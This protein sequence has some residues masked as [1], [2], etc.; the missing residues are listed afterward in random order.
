MPT[1]N[2]VIIAGDSIVEYFTSPGTSK[3]NH[4]KIKINLGATTE[5]IIDYIKPSIHKTLDFSLLHSGTNDLTNGINIMTKIQ[6]V[7][8]TVKEMDDKRK[9][10]LVFLQLLV[11]KM[12][13]KLM[14]L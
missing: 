4:V 7:V 12:L 14:K 13:T 3:K 6:K 1:K 8:V 2:S 10:K 9:I 5:H 11:R